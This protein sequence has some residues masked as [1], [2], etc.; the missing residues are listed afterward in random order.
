[1]A[2]HSF[3][4]NIS[5]NNPAGFVRY[6]WFHSVS[7]INYGSSA[8]LSGNYVAFYTIHYTAIFFIM[9]SL[10]TCPVVI[11]SILMRA[12]KE[13]I[14]FSDRFPLYL[15]MTD[16]FW[17]ASHLADHMVLVVRKVYP[18]KNAATLLSISLWFFLG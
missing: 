4:T 15:S 7:K 3:N 2:L 11:I 1:M 12:A 6:N 8:I 10:V 17:G 9:S 16:F 5:N 14:D 13:K 18:N